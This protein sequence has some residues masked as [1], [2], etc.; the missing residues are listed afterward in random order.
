MLCIAEM[1]VAIGH[2]VTTKFSV[3][4]SD[5]VIRRSLLYTINYATLSTWHLSEDTYA[6]VTRAPSEH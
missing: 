6:V 3:L 5:L 1:T 2:L 4:L